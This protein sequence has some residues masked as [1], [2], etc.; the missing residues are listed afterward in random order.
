MIHD[1]RASRILLNASIDKL[2]IILLK[3]I[4]TSR[5]MRISDMECYLRMS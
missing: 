1:V 2:Y 5:K 4:A 3:E